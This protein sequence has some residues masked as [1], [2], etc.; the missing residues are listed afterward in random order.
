MHNDS[1]RDQ[2]AAEL[3]RARDAA[4][5]ATLAPELRAALD[6][7][8]AYQVARVLHESLLDRGFRPVGR[9]IGF[10]NTAMW[11]QLKVNQPIW[12]HVYAQTIHFAQD[13]LARLNL[14]GMVGPRMEPEIVVK[15][16]RPL[17]SGEPSTAEIAGCLEWAA[18][19]FEIVDSHYP[20][21]RFSPVEAVADFGVHAAL[22]VGT[23][24]RLES[25]DPQHV[26]TTLQMLN[27]TLRGGKDF[28]A[29]GQGS[30]TLGS[31]LMAL[32]YLARVLAGQPWA[33]P[34]TVGEV[35]TTGTLT[36]LPTLRRGEIYRVEVAGVPLAPLQLELV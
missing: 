30:N 3:L 29:Q 27:V 22:V 9:K 6:L 19:G 7:D 32:G 1:I 10:T 8:R 23:P 36:T 25:E 12:G 31:P 13:G 4:Q 15:L 24:W 21:W 34:L 5:A 17:P 35:I 14:D 26:A 28:V 18:V 33:P 16:R 2:V 20:D 11:N